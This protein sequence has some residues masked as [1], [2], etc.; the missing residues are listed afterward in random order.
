MCR[1]GRGLAPSAGSTSGGAEVIGIQKM[2]RG[3]GFRMSFR[4]REAIG[5]SIPLPV[6]DN[7]ETRTVDNLTRFG[8][9]NLISHR[10]SDEFCKTNEASVCFSGVADGLAGRTLVMGEV[11]FLPE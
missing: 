4:V 1:A 7:S 9:E 8:H 5:T 3:S 11:H 2:R 10:M 6:L